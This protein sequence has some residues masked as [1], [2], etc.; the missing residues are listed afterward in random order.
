MPCL[1]AKYDMFYFF[2][3]H[4]LWVGAQNSI[5]SLNTCLNKNIPINKNHKNTTSII[6]GNNKNITKT[7]LST[8][9]YG[10][11]NTLITKN[12]NENL[13]SLSTLVD[14]NCT[15]T[16]DKDDLVFFFFKLINQ[17]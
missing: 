16:F 10:P 11:N 8:N 12:I 4:A 13:I 17:I 15:I 14:Q 5:L 9:I 3:F 7:T 6:W 2:P 1:G